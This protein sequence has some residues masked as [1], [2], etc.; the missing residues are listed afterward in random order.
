MSSSSR[1][2]ANGIRSRRPRGGRPLR[3][4]AK[5]VY[6]CIETVASCNLAMTAAQQDPSPVL[7]EVAPL[8]AASRQVVRELGML[9]DTFAPAGVTHSECHTL[10]EL[11]RAGVLTIG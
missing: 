8:R 10:L 9:E 6:T 4:R 3:R 1:M 7:S 11:A 2:R 5:V